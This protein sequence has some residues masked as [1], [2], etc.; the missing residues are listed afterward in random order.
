MNK[1]GEVLYMSNGRCFI[2]IVDTAILVDIDSV[3]WLHIYFD[4]LCLH[5]VTVTPCLFS[6]SLLLF[7]KS[8]KNI[9]ILNNIKSTSCI[10]YLALIHSLCRRHGSIQRYSVFVVYID[11]ILKA[12]WIDRVLLILTY[13]NKR[14]RDD[15][16]T[17]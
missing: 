7:A 2:D 12:A 3:S 10:S 5:W 17:V 16:N 1:I 14:N 4:T 13:R 8:K 6:V 15:I 9:T 11:H